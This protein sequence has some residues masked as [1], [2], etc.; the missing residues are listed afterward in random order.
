VI[1]ILKNRGAC[2]WYEI[3]QSDSCVQ[4][5]YR[6]TGDVLGH[7]SSDEERS[8]KI[9]W[10]AKLRGGTR[11]SGLLARA[12]AVL[13]QKI[14]EIHRAAMQ[15]AARISVRMRE[16]VSEY[17]PRKMHG[18]MKDGVSRSGAGSS[19]RCMA[20]MENN[21]WECCMSGR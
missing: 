9:S 21:Q 4:V 18:G 19:G 11:K 17:F 8:R 5:M 13:V 1:D 7:G 20:C 10:M 6:D 16:R 12:G 14:R 3:W 15:L 2:V